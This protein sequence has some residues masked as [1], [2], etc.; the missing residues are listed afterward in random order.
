MHIIIHTDILP[1]GPPVG[2]GPIDDDVT[3]WCEKVLR[4]KYIYTYL[5]KYMYVHMHIIAYTYI[6]TYQCTQL[7]IQDIRKNFEFGKGSRDR[8]KK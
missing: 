7:H 2:M 8:N 1:G 5:R 6:R 3:I 4:N